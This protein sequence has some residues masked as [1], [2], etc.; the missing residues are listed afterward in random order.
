[1]PSAD[2]IRRPMTSPQPQAARS[3][4]AATGP[5]PQAPV[6]PAGPPAGQRQR[7]AVLPNPRPLARP[8][9][10]PA[11][12]PIPEDTAPWDRGIFETDP[13]LRYREPGPG[14]PGYRGGTPTRGADPYAPDPISVVRLP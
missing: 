1:M 11:P 5:R 7:P 10:R 3:T 13:G 9:Q 14:M 12:D 2:P 4:R 6:P 8:A